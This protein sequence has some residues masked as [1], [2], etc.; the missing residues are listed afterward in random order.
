MN[1]WNFTMRNRINQGFVVRRVP[2]RS[3]MLEDID[4]GIHG[5]FDGYRLVQMSVH[6]DTPRMRSIYNGD[7]IRLSK[8]L[9]RFN[10]VR[11]AIN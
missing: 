6:F 2:C 4:S 5:H 7:I 8:T 3:H 9:P 11:T 10:D 1:D